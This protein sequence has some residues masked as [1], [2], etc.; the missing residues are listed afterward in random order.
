MITWPAPNQ[1]MCEQGHDE[2]MPSTCPSDRCGAEEDIRW[3]A[4]CQQGDRKGRTLG[5]NT[6]LGAKII[7]FPGYTE[8][9][10]CVVACFLCF[11]LFFVRHQAL[12]CAVFLF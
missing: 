3:I 12:T 11:R 7:L 8:F 5:A 2:H 10:N 9:P 1:Q 4:A 6:N